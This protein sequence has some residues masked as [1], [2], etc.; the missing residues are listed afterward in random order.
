M[1]RFGREAAALAILLAILCAIALSGASSAPSTYS[2]HDSGRNGYMALY[3]ALDRVHVPLGR[4]EAPLAELPPDARVFV[5]TAPAPPVFGTA[6]PI[7][8][9]SNDL[10]RLRGFLARG[11]TIIAFGTI[12]DL[13]KAKRLHVFNVDDYTN[14]ALDKTPSRALALYDEL[15]GRG[16]VVFDEYVHGYDRTRS[17]WAVLPQPVRVACWIAL[18]ALVLWLIDANLRFAPVIPVEP[19]ADRDSS[20][21]VRSMAHLLRRARAGR[22]TIARFAAAFPNDAQLAE[23]ARAQTPTDFAVLAAAV[24]FSNLSKGTT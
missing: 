7:V 3:G 16:P 23:L 24:R 18:A 13:S 11:G 10:K 12:R 2:S 14:S 21:Y 1:K 19:P 6:V 20:D 17:L 15:A 4:L 22:A 5:V 8:F 9:S